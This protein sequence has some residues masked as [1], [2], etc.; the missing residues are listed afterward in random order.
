MATEQHRNLLFVNPVILTPVQKEQQ[1][2]QWRR[3]TH[4]QQVIGIS[5]SPVRSD[6]ETITI[7]HDGLVYS[8]CHRYGDCLSFYYAVVDD[9][10]NLVPVSQLY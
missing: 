1:A 6:M 3:R 10:G 7:E 8:V 5:T 4:E 2:E 9:F